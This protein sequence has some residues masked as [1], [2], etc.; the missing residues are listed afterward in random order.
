[1]SHFDDLQMPSPL[2]W[3]LYDAEI[4]ELCAQGRIYEAY[5]WLMVDPEQRH[6]K[7]LPFRDV[8]P[9]GSDHVDWIKSLPDTKK[10]VVENCWVAHLRGWVRKSDYR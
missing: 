10:K 9:R 4:L 3:T 5:W 8:V 7:S 6:T 1:M 2:S